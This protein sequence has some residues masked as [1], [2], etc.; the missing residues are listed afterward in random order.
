MPQALLLCLVSSLASIFVMVQQQAY[1]RYYSRDGLLKYLKSIF[2][3]NRTF[4]IKEV[5]DAC[6]TFEAPRELTNQQWK[7]AKDPKWRTT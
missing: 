1:G 4:K 3:E 2:G 5:S 7:D 6:F